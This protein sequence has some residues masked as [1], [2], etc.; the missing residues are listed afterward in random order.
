M[1]ENLEVITPA[2]FHSY[3]NKLLLECK[4]ASVSNADIYH[5]IYEGTFLMCSTLSQLGYKEGI[6][7]FERLCM[8]PKPEK[9]Q[10]LVTFLN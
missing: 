8:T 7:I 1:A 5:A 6:E 10:N 4:E 3:M 9:S 2:V